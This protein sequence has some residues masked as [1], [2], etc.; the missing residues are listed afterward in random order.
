MGADYAVLISSDSHDVGGKFGLLQLD[1]T[2]LVPPSGKR[3]F[4]EKSMRRA[5]EPPSGS[6]LENSE[7]LKSIDSTVSSIMWEMMIRAAF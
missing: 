2:R 1:Q 3:I 6:F 5:V 4:A 7:K